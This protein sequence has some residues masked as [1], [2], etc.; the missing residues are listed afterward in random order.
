MDRNRLLRKKFSDRFDAVENAP[1]GAFLTTLELLRFFILEEPVLKELAER[2]LKRHE[3]TSASVKQFTANDVPLDSFE[4]ESEMAA[5]GL[6]FLFDESNSI[7]TMRGIGQRLFSALSYPSL[8]TQKQ[9]DEAKLDLLRARILAPVR[10]YFEDNLDRNLAIV[11]LLTRY[12]RRCEWFDRKNLL[13]QFMNDTQR[14]EAV[15]KV[16]LYRYLFDNGIDFEIEP[17]SIDGRIDILG[18]QLTDDPLVV[19]CKV[20]SSPGK[21]ATTSGFKQAVEY[22]LKY[23]EP[24]AYVVIFNVLK[25]KD[26]R[27]LEFEVSGTEFGYPYETVFN[28][29]VYFIEID[30]MDYDDSEKWVS[31]R[32]GMRGIV[33]KTADLVESVESLR[34]ETS[35]DDRII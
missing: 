29:R 24:V 1:F 26:K 12:K 20:L 23:N 32:Q 16:P 19:E 7:G 34:V 22:A 2:L 14:G 28:K 13:D 35:A 33:I 4:S 9:D 5:F 30:L 11:S 8:P 10:R 17:S 25:D 3:G 27:R 31:Q 6:Q 15:L 18:N 21:A